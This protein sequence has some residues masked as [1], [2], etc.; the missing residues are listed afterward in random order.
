MA[1]HEHMP[2][3]KAMTHAALIGHLLRGTVLEGKSFGQAHA[4]ARR[5]VGEDARHFERRPI[6]DTT[7]DRMDE[8]H[9]PS[10]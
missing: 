3:E 10:R 1:K 2:P 7:Y 9:Y 6:R 5:A 8:A 4:E